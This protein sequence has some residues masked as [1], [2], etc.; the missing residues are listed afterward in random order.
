MVFTLFRL[1]FGNK[2]NKNSGQ[3]KVDKYVKE[4]IKVVEQR[5]NN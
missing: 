1:I 2:E 5:E 4:M 3:Q